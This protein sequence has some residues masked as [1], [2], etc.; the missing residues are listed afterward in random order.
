MLAMLGDSFAVAQRRFLAI[1][2]KFAVNSDFKN[3][4]VKFMEEYKALGHMELSPRVENPQFV[5]PHH[6]I[7]HPDSS[8]TKTRVVFDATCKGSS[9]LSLND[10]LLVG[11]IVQPP[12]LAIVLNWRI[13][14]YVFNADA[15]KMF[16]QIWVHQ[17][18]RKFL[19][20][21]R[22]LSGFQ[23]L[24]RYQLTTVTYGTSCAPYLATR[25]LNQLA[26]N[27]G[28]RYPLGAKVILSGFY[29]D[30]ALSGE[31]DLEVAIEASKQ[32][33]ELLKLAG[34][35]LRKWSTN[36]TRVL[37]HVNDDLKEFSPETEIDGSGTVKTLGLLWSD[38]TDEFGFKIPALPPL[39]KVTKR[40]VASEMAQLFDPLGLVGSVVMSAKMFIQRLWAIHIP[41]DEE[42]PESLRVWWMRFRG[43]IPEL[44]KLKVPRRVLAN[45][46]NH[47]ALHCFC[48]AS[49]HGYGSCVYV[50]SNGMEKGCN[51]ANYSSLSLALHLY[52]DSLFQNSS[53]AQPSLAAS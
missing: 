31:D 16:R 24:Q 47:Y 29:M 32:L 52:V 22:R 5:L 42:L 25:V 33:E 36:D 17:L 6:A 43:E 12:L 30:D 20:V 21:L 27:E 45:T 9:Q 18:D 38:I 26:E 50:V 35:N 53:F 1:E 4:Y 3:E 37:A 11:P 2:R 34:F 44:S 19:Q 28:H 46:N 49:D 39:E 40:I 51:N 8:T 15:E 41:W 10:V 7:F 14:R 13:P 48:D 23:Q